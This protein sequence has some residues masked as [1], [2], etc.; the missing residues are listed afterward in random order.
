MPK[1]DILKP[2]A[3]INSLADWE[4]KPVMSSA[5]RSR[6]HVPYNTIESLSP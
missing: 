5:S 1:A 6:I 4:R 2:A 3:R